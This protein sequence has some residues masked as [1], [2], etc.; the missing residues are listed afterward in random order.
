MYISNMQHS[1]DATGNI[2][3]QMP[4]EARELASFLALVVDATTKTMPSTLTSTEIRCFKKGC[5]GFVKSS[6][7]LAT[8]E[9][10]WYCPDCE[11]EGLISEWQKTRWDNRAGKKR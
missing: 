11:N 3:K 2:P 7:R 10:H 5:H 6:M 1:L 4:K 9:I 8:N